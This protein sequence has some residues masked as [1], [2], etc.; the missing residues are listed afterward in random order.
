MTESTK[1]DEFALVGHRDRRGRKGA[2]RDC[3]F[4]DAKGGCEALVLIVEAS[5]RSGIGQAQIQKNGPR[6]RL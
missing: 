1:S 5:D 3:I 6:L 2:G 4:Q